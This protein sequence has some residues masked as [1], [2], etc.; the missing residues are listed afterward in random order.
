MKKE[1]KEIIKASI[2]ELNEQ[3]DDEDK[4]VFSDETRFIGSKACIDSMSFIYLFRSL[5]DIACG[6]II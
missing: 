1:I 5:T 6:F 4:V 2:D 3:L